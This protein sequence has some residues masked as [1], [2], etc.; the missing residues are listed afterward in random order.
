VLE[1]SGHTRCLNK[2]LK[3]FEEKAAEAP[4]LVGAEE[5]NDPD[6]YCPGDTGVQDMA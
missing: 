3:I 2:C 1:H 4:G 6:D 5:E